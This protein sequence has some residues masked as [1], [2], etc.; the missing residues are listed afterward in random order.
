M[1]GGGGGMGLETGETELVSG[2]GDG[3]I[4]HSD[5][6][7][8]LNIWPAKLTSCNM[9]ATKRPGCFIL[10]QRSKYNQ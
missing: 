10:N 6:F 9:Y 1:G 4:R 2:S 5:Y 7:K 3:D 8:F